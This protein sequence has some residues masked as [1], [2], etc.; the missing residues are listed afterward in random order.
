[1]TIDRAFIADFYCDQLRLVIELDGRIHECQQE[2][3]EYRTEILEAKGLKVLRFK[4]EEILNNWSFV[5]K[6]IVSYSLNP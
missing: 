4:N 1:M 6:S 3:D 2:Y 5:E